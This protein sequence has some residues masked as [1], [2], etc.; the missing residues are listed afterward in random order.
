[1]AEELTDEEVFGTPELS[2]EE[3]FGQPEPSAIPLPTDYQLQTS[4]EN[5]ARYAAAGGGGGFVTNPRLTSSEQLKGIAGNAAIGASFI[6]P[7]M[8]VAAVPGLAPSAAAGVLGYLGRLGV[9]GSTGAAAGGTV[10]QIPEVISGEKTVPK[11]VG[12]VGLQTAIGFPAGIV[13][14]VVGQK[15]IQ[16]LGSG[17]S[18]M[19][20]RQA[21]TVGE[22]AENFRRGVSKGLLRPI[23]QT[24]SDAKTRAAAELIESVT[25]QKPAQSLG[26]ALGKTTFGRS[27]VEVEK[28]LGNEAAGQLS[29]E[30][31]NAVTRSILH[32]ATG[33]AGTGASPAQ[34]AELTIAALQK[35]IGKNISGPAKQAVTE[36]SDQLSA[37]LNNAVAKTGAEAFRITTPETE[38]SPFTAGNIGK[39]AEQEA[40]KAFMSKEDELFGAYRQ[41]LGN[42][43][44]AATLKNTAKAVQS[45]LGTGLRSTNAAGE[46]VP[47]AST[48]TDS[49][50]KA[51]LG[52]INE[53]ANTPQD[54]E[55]LRRYR[56]QIGASIGEPGVLS[57]LGN[58]NKKALYKALSQD[59]DEAISK[60]PD[61]K[62]KQA[63]QQANAFRRENIDKFKLQS[64]VK[65]GQE[66]EEGGT[67]GQMLLRSVL[68]DTD[69]Y[70][71]FKSVLGD[72]FGTFKA[73][74]R[75]AVLSNAQ[76][77]GSTV[78]AE[79]AGQFNIGAALREI[80]KLPKE[81]ANDLFPGTSSRLRE[82]AVR[83]LKTSAL[84][85]NLPK[86]P[87]K[88]LDWVTVNKAELDEFLGP[89]G[90]A[91]F[92]DAIRLKAAE[93]ARYNNAIL[94]D[95]A[96]G[97]A[98]AISKNPVKFVDSILNGT[99][100]QPGDVKAALGVVARHSPKTYHD[101]QV[102]YLSRLIG[103]SQVKGIISGAEIAKRIA[104]PVA[105]KAATEGG[106][107]YDLSRE[108][109][110]D[111]K[112]NS[113]RTMATALEQT[114]KAILGKEITAR[115]T[116]LEMITAAKTPVDAAVVLG[117]KLGSPTRSLGWYRD[118]LN[119]PAQLK[120]QIAAK[121][122]N[123]PSMIPL[124]TKPIESLNGGEA[125]RITAALQQL[126]QSEQ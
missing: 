64:S 109:L 89:G 18:E 115:G 10:A 47:V 63:L 81:V 84:A 114:Q 58:A 6:A 9:L 31:R 56:S 39:M 55:A 36:L 72:Q 38:T 122:A 67:T 11:A 17:V 70:N 96:R 1:M 118:I 54:I 111:A 21:G 42:N 86:D 71:T 125:T 5:L 35:E 90:E 12:E 62:V 110:G 77:A 74:A 14:G 91:R 22:A 78:E 82:L 104:A 103:D 26:E 120:Y 73:T 48:I 85:K 80:E 2:D 117:A 16:G 116:L 124:L 97:D 98:T 69:R 79:A 40:E 29:E 92:Q 19:L 106:K 37:S 66:V 41:L 15:A 93:Q 95:V 27:F 75:D 76:R 50:V 60:I 51:F 4:P 101:L 65:A 100:S 45:I 102:A 34:L 105:G 30:A 23:F 99:F 57:D 113:L 119:K 61:P 121:L 46:V 7:E 8:L 43:P 28:E 13:G 25:G 49:K 83:E 52:Q 94:A 108:I 32:T 87:D 88:I 24:P 3:V 44:P 59:I 126:V 107:A 68:G 20:G 33:L 123:D 112:L 53:A